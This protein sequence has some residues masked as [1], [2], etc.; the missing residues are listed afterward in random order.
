MSTE[1]PRKRAKTDRQAL[2]DHAPWKPVRFD[3]ADAGALQALLRGD[4]SSDMQQRA[5]RF[6]IESIAGTYE[7]SYRPGPEGQRDTDF[8]EGRRFVGLQIVKL[9]KLN[10]SVLKREENNNA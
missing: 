5:L 4:A 3:L 10:L 7:V 1:Q 8:A 6:V 2:A 9:L